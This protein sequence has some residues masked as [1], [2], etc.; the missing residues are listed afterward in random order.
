[1]DRQRKQQCKNL[2]VVDM[3][4]GKYSDW[5]LYVMVFI[6]SWQ[7]FGLLGALSSSFYGGVVVG[8][9]E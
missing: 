5:V 1:M 6:L 8:V 7:A 4:I 9:C 2:R 3:G